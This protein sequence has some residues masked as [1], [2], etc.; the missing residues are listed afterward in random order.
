MMADLSRLTL[1]DMTRLG[2]ELRRLEGQADSM[3]AVAHAIGHRLY[4]EF[5]DGA[6]R[7]PSCALVRTF[8]TLPYEALSADQQHAA[9]GLLPAEP[10]P[11]LKCLTLLATTGIEPAWNDR[12][13]STGHQAI[14]LPSERGVAR[15]PMIAQL[16][17][18]L[19]LDIATVLAPSPDLVVDLTQHTFNVFH[20]PEAVGSP[21]IPAQEAFVKPYGIRSV[22]GFGGVLPPGELF[23]TILFSRVPIS[24]DAADLFKTLAL[25]VKVA[26]L[27]FAGARI[28]S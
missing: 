18:Q 24:R 6:T 1:S 7:G 17:R 20:V 23:A 12:R 14:P 4:E 19:G 11:G 16:I 25:N 22:V 21:H 3:E 26:L 27:P 13:K 2:A 15:L 10:T 8:V 5:T 28:F 9:A